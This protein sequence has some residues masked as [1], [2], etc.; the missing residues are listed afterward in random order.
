MSFIFDSIIS[1]PIGIIYNMIVHEIAELFNEKENY[2]EKLQKSLLIVFG[3]GLVGFLIGHVLSTNRS[4][5]FGMYLGSLLL[6][7]HVVMYNWETMRNDTRIIV[8]MLSL[9]VLVWYSYKNSNNTN[10][11]THINNNYDDNGDDDDNDDT[12]SIELNDMD[13]VSSNKKSNSLILL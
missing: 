1:L 6:I 13:N 5:K 10:N 7:A 9:V 4:L 3:G 11:E 8:M 12:E 2:N